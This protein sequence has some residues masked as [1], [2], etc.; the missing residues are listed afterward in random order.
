MK[1]RRQILIDQDSVLVRLLRLFSAGDQ[2]ILPRA[3]L[4]T[5][6]SLTPLGVRTASNDR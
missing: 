4:A 5:R 6:K 2:M 3:R 1:S